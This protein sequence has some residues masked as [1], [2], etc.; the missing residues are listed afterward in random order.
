MTPS[1]SSSSPEDTRRATPR[2]STQQGWGVILTDTNQG[3][4]EE[5][6]PLQGGKAIHSPDEGEPGKATLPRE[7]HLIEGDPLARPERNHIDRP[8]PG[9]RHRGLAKRDGL[10]RERPE[11]RCGLGSD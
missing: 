6:H 5:V 4:E 11:N 2:P 8:Y 3:V 10:E 1:A 7:R 9:E